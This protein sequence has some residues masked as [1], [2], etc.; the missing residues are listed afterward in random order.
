MIIL[1]KNQDKA[2]VELSSTDI[3]SI[4]DGDMTYL[5][6]LQYIMYNHRKD[7]AIIVDGDI[8]VVSGKDMPEAGTYIEVGCGDTPENLKECVREY[9]REKRKWLRGAVKGD[10]ELLK[11]SKQEIKDT[12][13]NVIL[14]TKLVEDMGLQ[15]QN[16][17]LELLELERKVKQGTATKEELENLD[18]LKRLFTKFGDHIQTVRIQRDQT[19]LQRDTFSWWDEKVEKYYYDLVDTVISMEEQERYVREM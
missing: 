7:V 3:Q 2:V 4:V 14:C 13:I 17:F 10:R 15:S 19:A 5:K 11:F 12:F 8:R 1:A 9:I 16:Y 18:G 6:H